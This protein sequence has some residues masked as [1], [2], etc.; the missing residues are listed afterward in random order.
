MLLES[1]DEPS[2]DASLL[3][4]FANLNDPR[5]EET[6][7]HLL[8]DMLAI[9]ICAIIC[10]AESWTD[11]EEYGKAKQQWLESFL[12]LPNGIPFHDTFARVLARLDPERCSRAF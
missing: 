11:I 8:L 3:T 6:I 10:G 2:V 7:E 4:H 12:S 5:Q 1:S 9:A